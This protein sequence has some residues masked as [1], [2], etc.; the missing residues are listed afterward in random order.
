M[1]VRNSLLRKKVG[2]NTF[3]IVGGGIAHEVSATEQ[4]A[5]SIETHSRARL[6]VV[7]LS[8]YT[9]LYC[10]ILYYTILYYAVGLARLTLSG[11]TL[12]EAE[13]SQY[14]FL[15]YRHWYR[16]PCCAVCT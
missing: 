7:L 1:S 3:E 15:C 9:V 13:Y 14:S 12:L 5:N 11:T 10:T 4:T 8:H 16:T 2:Q 6:R